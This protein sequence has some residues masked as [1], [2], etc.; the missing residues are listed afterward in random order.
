[1]DEVEKR[2]D[3]INWEYAD[4]DLNAI[5]ALEARIE[6]AGKKFGLISYSDLV[7]GLPFHYP[8]I[9]GGAPHFITNYGEWTGLDRKIIGDCLGFISMATYKKA[10]FFGS[11]IVIARLESKPSDIFFRWMKEMGVLKSTKEDDVLIFWANQV[12]RAHHWYAYGK[13]ID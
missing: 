3:A 10:K 5:A 2:F 12:K 11:A 9:S 13:M 6:T 4:K 8:N 7:A 1:M